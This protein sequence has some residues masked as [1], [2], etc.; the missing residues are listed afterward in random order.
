VAFSATVLV[1]TYCLWA[2]DIGRQH[3]ATW[4]AISIVPF[5][6]AVLRYAVEVDAGNG[7]GA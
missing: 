3:H 7:W 5:V 6:I 1:T 2:F 4:S